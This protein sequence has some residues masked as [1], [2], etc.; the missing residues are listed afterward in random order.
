MRSFKDLFKGRDDAHGEYGSIKGA[1]PTDRG[2]LNSNAA[3]VKGAPTQALF[4]AHIAGEKRLGIVCVTKEAKVHWLV[5]DVD[6]YGDAGQHVRIAQ[7]I[8]TCSLPLVQTASK[9]G[10]DHLWLF[11]E[12]P[13]LATRAMVLA[14]DYAERLDLP[15]DH[16]DIFPKNADPVSANFWVNLPYFGDTCWCLGESGSENLSM[17]EFLI[18]A[19]DR[20][21]SLSE[22]D[23]KKKSKVAKKSDAPPCIDYMIENGVEEGNRDLAM[24]QFIVFAKR[25][26]P[27][28]WKEKAQW[29]N[30]KALHP[31]LRQDEMRKCITSHMKKEYEYQC[32]AMKAIF[33]DANAC[34][35]RTYGV[36]SEEELEVPIEAIEKI[37]GE[38]PLYR[39]TLY[40]KTFTCQVDQLFHAHIFKKLAWTVTN[41]FVPSMKQ[42]VWEDILKDHM[43]AM[44]QTEAGRDTEASDRVITAFQD[45]VKTYVL[46]SN[47]DAAL[48][49]GAPY[50]DGA[51]LVFRGDA[52]MQIIDRSL[53]L[54]RDR[55]Y[56]YMR[57]W[58]VMT[59]NENGQK[60][61]C[62]PKRGPLW[63]SPNKVE[64]V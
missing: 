58:G 25:K 29:F 52:F 31:P 19:N 14:R 10:G 40:G 56:V 22:L 45:W 41:Q 32:K 21:T 38:V 3:S 2:K 50:W 57:E 47:L 20:I 61:W 11:F 1:K 30:D 18:Y 64:Q 26:W 59:I 42:T 49:A 60:L 39:V 8:R 12:E 9:S 63:F 23:A 7:A 15:K 13:I 37:D 35:K 24:Y 53:K 16:I 62:W 34:R 43:D 48:V 6:H 4:A 28:E 5:L 44:V 54:P 17:E 36:G 27:D 51:R 33:C 46:Y 55:V